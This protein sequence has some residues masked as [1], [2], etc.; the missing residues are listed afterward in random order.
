MGGDVSR[1]PHCIYIMEFDN[2][3]VEG[4]LMNSDN[5]HSYLGSCQNNLF[6]EKSLFRDADD[7]VQIAY[8]FVSKLGTAYGTS[9]PGFHRSHRSPIWAFS[10]P[11]SAVGR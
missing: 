6:V 2:L 10:V 11:K 3:K 5:Q 4:K 9:Y 1:W 7:A 8:A